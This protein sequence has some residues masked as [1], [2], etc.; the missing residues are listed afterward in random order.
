LRQ[1]QTGYVRSH[2]LVFFIGVVAVL[3][4]FS[5]LATVR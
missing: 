3:G 1:T 5:Y 4:Y 2:A